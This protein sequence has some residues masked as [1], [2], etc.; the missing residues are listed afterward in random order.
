M[1]AYHFFST[2]N[3]KSPLV[4]FCVQEMRRNSI[5]LNISSCWFMEHVMCTLS[6]R[7][8]EPNHVG[9]NRCQ[10]HNIV[11]R[12]DHCFKW[13]KN[14]SN[15]FSTGLCAF[16]CEPCFI[17]IFCSMHEKFQIIQNRL[18]FFY[19]YSSSVTFLCHHQPAHSLAA[20][21][22][23]IKTEWME[24]QKNSITLSFSSH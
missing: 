5:F 21:N 15:I 7:F 13:R 1:Y 12:W 3:F 18:V 19:S 20:I 16:A 2:N 14:I 17:M 9:T 22:G 11:H 24:W 10:M 23:R 6:N 4:R 8:L